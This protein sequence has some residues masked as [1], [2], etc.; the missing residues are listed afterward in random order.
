V[1][2]ITTRGAVIGAIVASAAEGRK[3]ARPAGPNLA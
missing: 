1:A 2:A 3:R